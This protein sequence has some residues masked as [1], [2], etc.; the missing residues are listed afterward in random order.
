MHLNTSVETTKCD[1]SIGLDMCATFPAQESRFSCT[2]KYTRGACRREE[3]LQNELNAQ[4]FPVLW[5]TRR[6]RYRSDT[7]ESSFVCTGCSLTIV[8]EMVYTQQF[9]I[10]INK[11]ASC[12]SVLLSVQDGIKFGP[13]QKKNW[14][15][16]SRDSPLHFVT[17]ADRCGAEKRL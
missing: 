17:L 6:G 14:Q 12:V 8:S 1:V 3:I 15:E 2:K 9:P 4:H 13:R 16:P 7:W 10:E 11:S 5:C